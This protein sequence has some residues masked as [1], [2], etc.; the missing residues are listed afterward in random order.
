MSYPSFCPNE[1]LFLISWGKPNKKIG[2]G[3]RMTGVFG[4]HTF[5]FYGQCGL[6][7]A[8]PSYKKSAFICYNS[9][10]CVLF[11]SARDGAWSLTC[12]SFVLINHTGCKPAR[13]EDA[14][15]CVST[16]PQLNNDRT[17]GQ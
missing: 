14:I 17:F 4:L 1:I 7:A 12:A 15:Y 5:L 16:A 11:S 10:I 2:W 6:E 13:A 8:M 3:L 9:V